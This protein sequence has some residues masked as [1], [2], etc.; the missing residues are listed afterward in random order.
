MYLDE[1]DSHMFRHGAEGYG[2]EVYGGTAE[3]RRAA[4]EIQ[5]DEPTVFVDARDT[6]DA[7]SLFTNALTALAGDQAAADGQQ[8]RTGRGLRRELERTES[9]LVIVGFD[10]LPSDEQTTVAQR[11]KGIAEGLRSEAVK[12]GYMSESGGSV[13]HAEPDLRMRVK[14]WEIEPEVIRRE[15]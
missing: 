15:L 13:V 6:S 9:N 4:F 7:D 5:F 8:R 12:L 14:S 3:Q 1:M 11:M 2:V 10:S